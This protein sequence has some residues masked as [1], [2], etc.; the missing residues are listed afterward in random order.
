MTA[1]LVALGIVKDPEKLMKYVE[2]SAP[3]VAAFGGELI[4]VGAVKDVLVGQS[5]RQRV[6]VFKFPSVE[7]C[8]NWF[9]SP[10][11]KKL[12]PLRGEAGDFDFLVIEEF[13]T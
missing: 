13:P 4:T 10:G 1:F 6:A 3:F 12:W 2:S 9:N 11:Y 5:T 8:R 7:A